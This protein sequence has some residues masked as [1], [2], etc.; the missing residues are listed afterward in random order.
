VAGDFFDAV[1]SGGD[2]Y[3]LKSVLHNWDDTAALRILRTCRLAMAQRARLLVVERVLPPGNTSSE[4]KLFDI[5]MLVVAAGLERTEREYGELFEAAGF[6][7][8]RIIPTCSPLSLIE[9]VPA[10]E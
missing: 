1:P 9:G 8:T 10:G 3:L 5:N 4:A 6:K 2:L 7:L